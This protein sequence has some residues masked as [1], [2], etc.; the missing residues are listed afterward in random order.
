MVKIG[1]DLAVD[2][3]LF[4]V[5]EDTERE[6]VDPDQPQVLDDL[7]FSWAMPAGGIWPDQPA[8]MPADL[9]LSLPAFYDYSDIVRGCRL[10]IELLLGDD[11]DLQPF[12]TY[13]GRITDATASPRNT[14]PDVDDTGVILDLT[15]IDYTVDTLEV[16]TLP[17]IDP[18]PGAIF[19]EVSAVQAGFGACCGGYLPTTLGGPWPDA[20]TSQNIN[21]VSPEQQLLSPRGL[22]DAVLRQAVLPEDGPPV[23][24]ILAPLIDVAGQLP[25]GRAMTL[26][27]VSNSTDLSS[28]TFTVDGDSVDVGVKWTSIKGQKPDYVGA[29]FG[30]GRQVYP[31][32]VVPPGPQP[33]WAKRVVSTDVVTFYPYDAGYF[34]YANGVAEFYGRDNSSDDPWTLDTVRVFLDTLTSE[35]VAELPLTL[36]PRWDLDELDPDRSACYATTVR[37]TNIEPSTMPIYY[38][39]GTQVTAKVTGAE[40]RLVDGRPELTL[41]LRF[42]YTSVGS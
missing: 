28:P 23:R 14:Q 17:L 13:Y 1:D 18:T 22:I 34:V 41:S 27:P 42:N 15:G 39:P 9:S 35:Q 21:C 2:P 32:P 37:I 4:V 25:D 36:F 10:S 33:D 40:L 19:D 5:D 20:W 30:E 29:V 12:A 24:M 11:E 8:A 16:P 7:R 6:D 3:H 31:N 26:D 38:G